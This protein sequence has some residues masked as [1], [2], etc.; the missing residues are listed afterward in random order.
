[1]T[2]K[3]NRKRGQVEILHVVLHTI[4]DGSRNISHIIHKTGLPHYSLKKPLKRMTELGW[5]TRTYQGHRY[6]PLYDLTDEGIT[7]MKTLGD[8]VDLMKLVLDDKRGRKKR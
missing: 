4:Y 2:R 8:A 6:R 1:M 3:G 5:M 7:K